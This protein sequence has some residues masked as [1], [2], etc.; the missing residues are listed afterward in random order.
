M[1]GG[2]EASSVLPGAR[3]AQISG[4]LV[5][6]PQD[7][8]LS[9]AHLRLEGTRFEGTLGW[10]RDDGRG[11]VTGTLATDAL[12]ADA[13][14]GDA[15]DGPQGQRLYRL[16]LATSPLRTDI[17]LRVSAAAARFGRV[18]FEDAAFAALARGDRL[19]LSVDG[20]QAYGGF[21][22]GRAL[23][24]LGPHG[25]DAHVE[26]S[27]KAVDLASL[28]DDLTGADRFAGR[29][30][31][32]VEIDGH[33]ASLEGA[34]AASAG[35]GRIGIENGRLS[36]LS[37]ARALRRLGRRLP[38]D[39]DQRGTPTTFDAAQ[40]DVSVKDGVLRIPD[41]KLTAPGVAMSFG[42]ATSLPDGRIDVHAVA[43]EADNAGSPRRGG[44][45]LPFDMSGFWAGPLRVTG[46]D[47]ALPGLVLPLVD[48]LSADR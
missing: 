36:G 47:G 42:A 10:R 29:L 22:K 41:G 44:P 39:A 34:V 17:D 27:A 48:G 2:Q 11:V 43:R 5:A 20:A 3:R 37:L 13:L 38:A 16:P 32:A 40:W 12:D 7:V 25:I 28:S 46:R 21:V 33:G 15:L 26:L 9:N 4:D 24:T 1:Q 8:S 30:T 19:E 35:G 23:A 45:V 14:V 18:A 6:R 31:G